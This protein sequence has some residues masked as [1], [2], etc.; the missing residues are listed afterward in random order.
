MQE[1]V[2]VARRWKTA[3]TLPM[4]VIAA[5]LGWWAIVQHAGLALSMTG[6]VAVF[7]GAASIPILLLQVI[8]PPRLRL[9]PDVMIFD[10]G[11]NQKVV[12][13][14]DIEGFYLWR[15]SA[16]K[17][18]ALRYKSGRA[19]QDRMT[20]LMHDRAGVDQTIAAPWPMGAEAMVDVLNQARRELVGEVAAYH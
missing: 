7:F 16:A 5:G 6:W 10:T 12:P 11:L 18:P 4:A 3:L 13:W 1:R 15:M 14:A 20:R 19:P 2:I 8:R 17:F 9:R